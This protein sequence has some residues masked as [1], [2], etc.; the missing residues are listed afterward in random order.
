MRNFVADHQWA[1]VLRELHTAHLT[2]TYRCYM[3]KSVETKIRGDK[4]SIF[5]VF[6]VSWLSK[7]GD[8]PNTGSLCECKCRPLDCVRVALAV[9]ILDD[10]KNC[11]IYTLILLQCCVI[12][13]EL[14][15]GACCQSAFL[16]VE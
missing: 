10:D 13:G 3:H 12:L 16:F 6:T 5:T 2:A 9:D 1:I 8:H 15:S 4:C 11:S 7:A 14:K